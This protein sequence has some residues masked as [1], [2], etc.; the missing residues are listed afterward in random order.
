MSSDSGSNSSPIWLRLGWLGRALAF[1]YALGFVAWYFSFTLPNSQVPRGQVW[2]WSLGLLPDMTPPLVEA[3][4]ELLGSRYLGQRIA[5]LIWGVSVL[6]TS[7]SAGLLAWTVLE[8]CL[9][10]P[11]PDL[12]MRC[13]LYYTLGTVLVANATLVAGLLG[14]LRP[15]LFRAAMAV[16]LAS[17][18]MVALL[19][20][21]RRSAR[22]DGE[23]VEP[24]SWQRGIWLVAGTVAAV[25][26]VLAVAGSLL[27]AT[28]FDVREYHLQ[29]PKEYFLAG[30]IGF[31]EHNVYT[32]MPFGTEMLSLFAMVV[33]GDWWWGALAGQVVLASYPALT[34][35]AVVALARVAFGSA[36]MPW[37]LL[38]AAST[39][40]FYRLATIPYAEGG[41][42]F[43]TAMAALALLP[44]LGRPSRRHDERFSWLLAGWSAAAAYGTKY[45]A[46]LFIVVPVVALLAA[47]AW[48]RRS[49]RVLGLGLL[50][51]AA[52]GGLWPLKNILL[53]GNP[54]YPLAYEL[55]GGR[56]WN[57]EKDR[58]WDRGHSVPGYRLRQLQQNVIDVV[59]KS[60]WQNALVFAF[61]PLALAA[62]S[63]HRRYA[64][65]L[66]LAVLY[67]FACWWLATHRIDRFWL[68]L[69]P[70]ACT[71]AAGGLAWLARDGRSAGGLLALAGAVAYFNLSLMASPLT[72]NNAYGIPLD[73]RLRD[74]LNTATG[75]VVKYCNARLLPTE[76]VLAVG[77]ADLFH[78]NRDYAYNTVFDDCLFER[79]TAGKTPREAVAALRHRGFT[80]L[81]V[82]WEEILRYRNT[83]GYTD[84]VNPRLLTAYER[85]GVVEMEY[86]HPDPIKLDGVFVPRG[87]LYRLK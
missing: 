19:Q 11:Q 77:A 12:L 79:W 29:G 87:V 31:L 7:W 55:F 22:A 47:T 4:R 14:L 40:W 51:A 84:Y 8:R 39:P 13:L 73:D 45:T 78:L 83:Y 46:A 9:K 50:A 28:D 33:S 1:A 5:P 57:A 37:A 25:A 52:A 38:V 44:L 86:A 43:Y 35:V 58:K 59:A 71:L 34:G 70:V 17:A 69:L 10:L 66:W 54:V 16:T 23:R 18:T 32:N 36:A 56:N 80:H 21:R 61:A 82:C 67:L 6:L 2:L 42:C 63:G 3:F 72:G 85:A 26:L 62:G 48:Q 74:P 76:R 65:A 53:T 15:W 27:P 68:P 81:F 20:E 64:V 24:A 75:A 30:R 60:D 49:L 41:Y